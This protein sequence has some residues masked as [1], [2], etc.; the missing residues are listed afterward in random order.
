MLHSIGSCGASKQPMNPQSS[1][2][3]VS[4][5]DVAVVLALVLVLVLDAALVDD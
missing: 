4:S 2:V 1:P 5:A 3:V